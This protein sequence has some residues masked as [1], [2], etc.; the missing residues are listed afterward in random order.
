MN[1]ILIAGTGKMAR[2]VG[3]RFLWAGL[4]VHWLARSEQSLAGIEKFATRAIRRATR[5]DPVL[6][7][8]VDATCSTLAGRIPAAADAIF[9]SVAEDLSAKRTVVSAI[10]ERAGDRVPVLTNSSS[11]AP[12]AIRPGAAGLHFFY[13]VELTTFAEIIVDGA[14]DAAREVAQGMTR[15]M[16]VRSVEETGRGAFAANRCLLPIQNEI[17]AALEGG[18]PAHKLDSL[19][20]GDLLPAGQISIMESIGFAVMAPAVSN[21]VDAMPDEA[22]WEFGPLIRGLEGWS[23]SYSISPPPAKAAAGS[24]GMEVLGERLGALF[25]NTCLKM[26]ERGEVSADQMDA[27]LRGALGAEKPLRE[28]LERIGAGR[29]AAILGEARRE[30][31]RSYYEPS[32]LLT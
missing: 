9:E 20:L 5:A 18:V 16:G 3:A 10:V 31:G 7:D 19:S 22:A 13:P 24:P 32:T 21:Y 30:T 23:R 2:N 29:L 26:I 27:I 8:R 15:L 1:R 6:Q 28:E 4:S 11:I 14:S 12:S 25:V 17:F